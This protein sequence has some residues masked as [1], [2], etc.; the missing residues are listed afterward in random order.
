MV[1]GA[2]REALWGDVE[3]MRMRAVTRC[4]QTATTHQG[5]A[6]SCRR[7]STIVLGCKE[8][9][10]AMRAATETSL[11][12]LPAG[13]IVAQRRVM[14]AARDDLLANRSATCEQIAAETRRVLEPSRV[15]RRYC[16][17]RAL[18]GSGRAELEFEPVVVIAVALA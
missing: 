15:H 7:V 6:A 4:E 8:R 14:A 2:W 17:D 1:A 9:Q 5:L 18:G 16:G 3:S 10:A 13:D 11:R 12:Q